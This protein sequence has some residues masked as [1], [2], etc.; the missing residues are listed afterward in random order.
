MA[1]QGGKTWRGS[2]LSQWPL[3]TTVLSG[4]FCCPHPGRHSDGDARDRKEAVS[5]L[6]RWAW[7]HASMGIRKQAAS[8][9]SQRDC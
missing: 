4:S 8:V 3:G 2:A 9:C 5:V 7:L 1:D 6:G